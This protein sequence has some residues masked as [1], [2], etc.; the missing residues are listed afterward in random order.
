MESI[1]RVMKE[2]TGKGEMELKELMRKEMEEMSKEVSVMKELLKAPKAAK[3]PKAA[4]D[5]ASMI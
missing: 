3:E 1:M 5:I 4:S 2:L